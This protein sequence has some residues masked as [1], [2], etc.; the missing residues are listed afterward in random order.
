V[1]VAANCWVTPAGMLG[2]AGV[3]D[4]EDRIARF[5]V[6][7]VLPEIPPEVAVMVEVPATTAVARPLPLTVAT[8][9][10]DEVQVTCVVISWL[11]PSEYVPVAANCWVT[12]AGMLGLTGV[13]DME[14][15]IAAVTVSVV[16]PVAI[17]WEV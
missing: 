6:R 14:D 8:D 12:P 3:T 7:A 10:L 5:T 1:P 2:L 4:R 9:V 17:P 11:V 15:R 13:T 16:L